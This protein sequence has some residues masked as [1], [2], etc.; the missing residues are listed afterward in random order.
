M[1][2]PFKF[3]CPI[4][5]LDNVCGNK[6]YAHRICKYCPNN[7]NGYTGNYIV[8]GDLKI[9]IEIEKVNYFT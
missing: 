4:S 8:S 5:G 7:S 9:N 6:K 1:K 3:F 2:E